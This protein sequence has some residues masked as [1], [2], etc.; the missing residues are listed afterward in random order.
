[1]IKIRIFNS[2]QYCSHSADVGDSVLDKDLF[3]CA[4]TQCKIT[5]CHYLLTF[6]LIQ[7]SSSAFVAFLDLDICKDH[8]PLILRSVP[9]VVIV[10]CSLMSVKMLCILDVTTQKPCVLRYIP[11]QKAHYAS[12]FLY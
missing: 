10:R 7:K 12:L 11:Y 6:P 9:H 5:N 2:T 4:G 3:S 1:M 8:R